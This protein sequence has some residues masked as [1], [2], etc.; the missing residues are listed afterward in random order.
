MYS[1]ILSRLVLEEPSIYEDENQ[2]LYTLSHTSDLYKI[3]FKFLYPD[4]K[5]WLE[6]SKV[7]E[8]IDSEVVIEDLT[9]PFKPYSVDIEEGSDKVI[10]LPLRIVFKDIVYHHITWDPVTQAITIMYY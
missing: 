1:I 9:L 4:G 5:A 7:D 10:I 6:K 2:T 8:S 3:E